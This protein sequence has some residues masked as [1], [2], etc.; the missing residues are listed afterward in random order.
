MAIR[1]HRPSWDRLD[2]NNK[3]AL[4]L[5]EVIYSLVRPVPNRQG[6]WIQ[7][8]STARFITAQ[9]FTKGFLEKQAS[10]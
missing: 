5:H 10:V 8:A 6:D 1:I 7:P 9:V 3:A 4:V 2:E